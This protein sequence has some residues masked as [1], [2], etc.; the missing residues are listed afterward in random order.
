MALSLDDMIDISYYINNVAI[1]T[2]SQIYL[3]TESIYL[4]LRPCF[5]GHGLDL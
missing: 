5:K 3:I 1:K 2:Y 4:T